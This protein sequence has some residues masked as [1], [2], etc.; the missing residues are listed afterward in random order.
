MSEDTLAR[1]LQDAR[2]LVVVIDA[3]AS[4]RM[5]A[6]I[7]G[8][9]AEVVVCR[10]GTAAH[11]AIALRERPFDAALLDAGLRAAV[12]IGL[13]GA[14]HHCRRPCLHALVGTPPGDEVPRVT[15]RTGPLEL[16]PGDGDAAA[17][18]AAVVRVAAATRQ[19]RAQC[20][21]TLRLRTEARPETLAQPEVRDRVDAHVQALARASGLSGRECSVLR[22]IAQGY[23]YQDI[24]RALCISKSTVKMHTINL[25]RKLGASS[26]FEV[27]RRIFAA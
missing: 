13:A 10:T 21:R 8:A 20:E 4:V 23:R 26:R 7:A 25:R 6:A 1:P 24:A 22:Y 14:L 17:L 9:G 12:R 2:V 27:Q 3:A 19:L 16:L 11:D 18:V 5:A 15:L